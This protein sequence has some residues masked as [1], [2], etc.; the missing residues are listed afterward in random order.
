MAAVLIG[1]TTKT[2][3]YIIFV[4][5]NVLHLLDKLRDTVDENQINTAVLQCHHFHISPYHN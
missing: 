1:P 3:T 4:G 2:P 5:E